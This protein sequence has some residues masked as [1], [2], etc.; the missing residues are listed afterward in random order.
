MMEMT[1]R[2]ERLERQVRQQRMMLIAAGIAGAAVLLTG[3]AAGPPDTI[4]AKAIRIVD[5]GGKPRILIGAPPPSDGRVRKDGQTASIVVLGPDG[6]DRVVMG[7]APNPRLDGKSYPRVAAAYGLIISDNNG[8][9]RGAVNY[10]DNG[11][12]VIALDRPGGDAVSMIVNEQSGFAGFTVNYANPLGK[13]EE[14][15]RIGTKGDEAWL[16]LQDR[17]QGERARLSTAGSAAPVLV[18]RPAGAPPAP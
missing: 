8:S 2:L 14:G 9:E 12:G 11:R 1:E 13:Y 4:E 18:T 6:Q 3:F 7:E 17:A 15:W 5:A 10:L 16:S